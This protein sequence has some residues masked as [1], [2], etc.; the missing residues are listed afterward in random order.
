LKLKIEG[1]KGVAVEL[2]GQKSGARE[3]GIPSVGATGLVRN[4]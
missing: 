3:L 2:K 4:N 1:G